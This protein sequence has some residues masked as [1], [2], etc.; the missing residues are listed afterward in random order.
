MEDW[1]LFQLL[2][3]RIN[4]FLKRVFL[5]EAFLQLECIC[6]I[7]VMSSDLV[8][9]FKCLVES[10]SSYNNLFYIWFCFFGL[11]AL[12]SFICFLVIT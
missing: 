11:F 5:S 9:L 2:P 8:C 4:V 12:S 1:F 6:F 10:V 3:Y 7:K